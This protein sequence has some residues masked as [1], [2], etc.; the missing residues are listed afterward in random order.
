MY[1]AHTSTLSPTPQKPVH[2]SARSRYPTCYRRTSQ[3][4]HASLW[5]QVQFTCDFSLCRVDCGVPGDF[6]EVYG[7][8]GEDNEHIGQW[9]A[10]VTCFFIDT[11]GPSLHLPIVVHLYSYAIYKAKNIVNY[12]RIFHTILAS[13]GVWINL[14]D[15]SFVR[16]RPQNRLSKF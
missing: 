6:E 9:D 3:L 14:G 1:S 16:G 7:S 4:D 15:P 10:I 2:Y 8:P 5:L 12:L 13:G 11:V